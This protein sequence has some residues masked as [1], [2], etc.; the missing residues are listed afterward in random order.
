MNKA[1][2]RKIPVSLVLNGACDTACLLKVWLRKSDCDEIRNHSKLAV[3]L[4]S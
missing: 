4:H 1:E 2:F 3:I